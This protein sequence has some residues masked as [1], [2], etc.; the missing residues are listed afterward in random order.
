MLR[1][2]H[3]HAAAGARAAAVALEVIVSIAADAA[4][5]GVATLEAIVS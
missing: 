3:S 5:D 1:D 2:Q 4:V